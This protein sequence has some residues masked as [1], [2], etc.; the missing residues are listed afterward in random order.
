M[1]A[2]E[3]PVAE[4]W[5]CNGRPSDALLREVAE[6]MARSGS[7][8]LGERESRSSGSLDKALS[9]PAVSG[10]D[11]ASGIALAAPSSLEHR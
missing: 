2:G 11:A 8:P 4:E 3:A 7:G 6:R 10:R 1:A 5:M 9:R